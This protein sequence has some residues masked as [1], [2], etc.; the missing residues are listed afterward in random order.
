MAL[1]SI[2]KS[3]SKGEHHV[4]NNIDMVIT[5]SDIREKPIYGLI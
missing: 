1:T 5:L 3:S 2:S 4:T